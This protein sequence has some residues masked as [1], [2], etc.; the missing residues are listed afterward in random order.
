MSDADQGM[1]LFHESRHGVLCHVASDQVIG[2][3]LRIYGEWAEEELWLLSHVVRRGDT[4]LDLGA[5]VG[6]HSLAFSRFTGSTGRV[7]AI[8]AQAR[9]FRLLALNMALNQADCV[10]PVHALI[11]TAP[12]LHMVAEPRQNDRNWGAANFTLLAERAPDGPGPLL[13]LP[14]IS[15]D[16]LHLDCCDLMKLDIEGMELDAVRGAVET[17]RRCK[18]TIYFEQT[19]DRNFAAIRALLT[20]CGYDLF[21][22]VARPFNAANFRRNHHNHFGEAR[23]VNVIALPRH[24]DTRQALAPFLSFPVTDDLYAPPLAEVDPL[25]WALPPGAYAGLPPTRTTGRWL[26]LF[27]RG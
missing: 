9:A 22:H 16:S 12:T 18:P 25:G 6:T 5:N 14:E 1:V 27:R 24:S 23:E 4:I 15:I 10:V 2:A 21:W 26:S 19:T 7:I 17:M 13:P 11:G 20:E 8:D 3:S